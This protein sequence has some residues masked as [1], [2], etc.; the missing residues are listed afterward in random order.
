MYLQHRGSRNDADAKTTKM[1]LYALCVL[2]VLSLV[3]FALDT[4]EAIKAVSKNFVHTNLN[5]DNLFFFNWTLIGCT[6]GW[7]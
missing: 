7:H 1:L 2:Y 4:M 3:T 6:V 5:F